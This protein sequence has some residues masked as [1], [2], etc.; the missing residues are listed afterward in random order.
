MSVLTH[1]EHTTGGHHES[2]EVIDHRQRLG[3]WLF[4]A[5]DVVTL[6]AL[7]FTYLYLR[8]TNT[9]GSWRSVVGFDFTGKT[10]AQAQNLI[11]N[12]TPGRVFEK[13]VSS[14]LNWAIVVVVALSAAI[15]AFGERKIREGSDRALV[16]VGL[17]ASA[18]AVFA[19]VLAVIQMRSI[20]QF[21]F[22]QND[23]QLFIHTAYGSAMLALSGALVIHLLL[24]AFLGVG[25]VLRSLNGAISSTKWTQVRLVRFFWVW[26]AISTLI[27]A[28]VTTALQ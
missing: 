8:G 4:I 9:E 18:V 28:A 3:I 19:A 26:V 5:G 20:P 22:V 27:T 25:I 23:S 13:A 6:A 14:G 10:L 21:Y 1:D 24:L 11:D 2:P 17:A 12:G 15:F 7:L 16:P